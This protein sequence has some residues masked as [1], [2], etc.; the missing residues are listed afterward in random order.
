MEGMS[1]QIERELKTR[2]TKNVS[3]MKL[4][5]CQVKKRKIRVLKVNLGSCIEVISEMKY[6][7]L[8]RTL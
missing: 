2:K 8:R 5:S 3:E 6:L 1:P 7:A 4:P